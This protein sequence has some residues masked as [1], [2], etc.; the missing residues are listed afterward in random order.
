M[1]SLYRTAAAICL[2]ALCGL[3]SEAMEDPKYKF[4]AAEV[5]EDA[6]VTVKLV[7]NG[8]L[9]VHVKEVARDEK[10]ATTLKESIEANEELAKTTCK[11]SEIQNLKTM[12]HYIFDYDANPDYRKL[13]QDALDKGLTVFKEKK[14]ANAENAWVEIWKDDAG[15]N[16]AYLLGSN[17]TAIACVIGK[18]TKV[19]AGSS[20]GDGEGGAGGGGGGGRISTHLREGRSQ[21]ND[22]TS[23]EK[24][25]LFCELSPAA[26]ADEAPFTEEYYN[27]LIARTAS[28]KEMTEDDLKAPSNDGVAPGAIPAVLIAGFLAMLTA[29]AA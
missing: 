20:G 16:L 12:F 23:A 4:T 26:Q 28:L 21:Q 27:G 22:E 5:T 6:Y 13:L 8:Q 10:L 2:A 1:A 19:E 9:P 15:A 18:C 11:S 29:V 7:R 25:A 14:S 3:K 24:A 17:S